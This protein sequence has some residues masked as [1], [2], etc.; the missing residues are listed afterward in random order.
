MDSPLKAHS[1][2]PGSALGYGFNL[3]SMIKLIAKARKHRE[4]ADIKGEISL[5]LYTPKLC[6][7][8]LAPSQC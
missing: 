2:V 1:S 4:K 3:K 5:P 8:F 7:H 6:Y